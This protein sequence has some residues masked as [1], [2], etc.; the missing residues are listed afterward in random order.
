[1]TQCACHPDVQ[2]YHDG[3]FDVER[4][5]SLQHHVSGC[6]KCSRELR[7]LKKLSALLAIPTTEEMTDQEIANL[8]RAVDGFMLDAEPRT[9]AFPWLKALSAAAASILIISAAWLAQGPAT[10]D[11]P[12]APNVA[13][14]QNDWMRIAVTLQVDPPPPGFGEPGLADSQVANWFLENLDGTTQHA[15]N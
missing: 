7:Q 12:Q 11:A 13:L 6:D 2:P 5:Q 14:T 15:N 4:G 8:H 1:M 10:P 3:E 9:L